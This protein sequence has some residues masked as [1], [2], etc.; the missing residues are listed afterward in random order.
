MGL[1]LGNGYD[2]RGEE[3]GAGGVKILAK[4]SRGGGNPLSYAWKE[5][6]EG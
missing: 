2:I 6:E 1:S 4:K 3:E 5:E